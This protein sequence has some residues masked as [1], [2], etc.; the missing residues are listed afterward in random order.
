M[1]SLST[2]A[3]PERYACIAILL[4][5]LSFSITCLRS[6][7]WL[8]DVTSF[9]QVI[10]DLVRQPL[11]QSPQMSP[12]KQELISPF[13]VYRLARHDATLSHGRTPTN[14]PGR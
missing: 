7:P 10:R 14:K 4:F 13:L 11:E 1:T 12:Q 9:L 6:F 8:E 3:S 5:H 2:E